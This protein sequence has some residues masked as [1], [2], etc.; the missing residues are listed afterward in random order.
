[1]NSAN[2]VNLFVI[3]DWTDKH[4]VAKTVRENLYGLI[5]LLGLVEKKKSVAS[6]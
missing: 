2:M 5:G 4:Q 6:L 1:M 3:R